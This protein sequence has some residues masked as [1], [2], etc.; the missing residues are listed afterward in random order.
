MNIINDS[1]WK[2]VCTGE[3][4]VPT[5][6]IMRFA[7][8]AMRGK[9]LMFLLMD[10]GLNTGLLMR[11][12]MKNN[13]WTYLAA[14]MAANPNSYISYE[15]IIESD[16]DNDSPFVDMTPYGPANPEQ[17][18]IAKERWTGLKEETRETIEL[19]VDCPSEILEEILGPDWWR[20][21]L[22]Q[23][24]VMFFLYKR[25]GEWTLT[26]EII[27]EIKGFLREI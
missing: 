12:T 10:R 7:R 26:K 18:L 6:I 20:K 25:L 14:M 15:V 1:I 13:G 5:A 16:I 22:T 2:S 9:P 17:A 23:K 27:S 11:L 3:M 8:N 21:R 19:L 24:K 4:D